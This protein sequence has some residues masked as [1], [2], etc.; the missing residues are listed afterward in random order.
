MAIYSYVLR[1]DSGVAPNPFHN[2]C[3]LAI[4]KPLIR[5]RA[6]AGDWVIGSGSRDNVNRNDE[7]PKLIYAMRVEEVLPLVV[8][9]DDPRFK[10][11][12]PNPNA[13]LP[14]LWTGDNIYRSF[15]DKIIQMPSV[16]SNPDF[17][18]N[19]ENKFHD[20]KGQNVLISQYF[21][22]FGKSAIHLPSAFEHFIK[23]NQGYKK[24]INPTDIEK[25]ETWISKQSS[26]F[27]FIPNQP[28]SPMVSDDYIYDENCRCSTYFHNDSKYLEEEEEEEIIY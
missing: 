15:G 9:F 26:P 24:I 19:L 28:L 1:Y 7:N 14:H 20:L 4:C 22:Y 10:L 6:K 12:K 23:R 2:Y 17:S 18:E 11:K 16:H 13:S 5:L 21:W 25:F 8:Y 3:T 27:K